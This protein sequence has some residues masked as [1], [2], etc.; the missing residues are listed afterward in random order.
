MEKWLRKASSCVEVLEKAPDHIKGNP[1]FVV[2]AMVR[3]CNAWK[4]ASKILWT[5]KDVVLAVVKQK[6][7]ALKHA[8]EELKNDP[9]VVMTA[10]KENGCAYQFASAR[11]KQDRRFLLQSVKATKASWLVKFCSKELQDDED[12]E[13]QI[14]QATGSGLI[15][16]Y[17]H[18]HNGF[19]QLGSEFLACMASVP[20]GPAY[21]NVMEELKKRAK[22]QESCTSASADG[23]LQLT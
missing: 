23:A 6:G 21:D 14:L 16:T 12:L 7:E 2:S 20:G 15:F 3:S 18:S 5:N 22:E 13:K 4:F 19:Y 9:E 1:D 10:L 11:L 17:Y 8:S